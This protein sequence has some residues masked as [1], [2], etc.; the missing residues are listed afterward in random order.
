[1]AFALKHS[2]NSAMR[3]LRLPLV[4]GLACLSMTAVASDALIAPGGRLAVIDTAH[5]H[6][7]V[8]AAVAEALKPRIARAEV[9]YAA[10]SKDAGY[11][12]RRLTL[13]VTDDLDTHNGFS[14]VTPFPIINVQLAPSL[15][16]SFI[17]TGHDEF[18]RTLIHELAHHIS[19]DRDPNAFRRTL[20]HIF[21]RILPNDPLSLAVAYLSTPSHQTMPSFWHEGGA[22][23]A[24][25]EYATGP[26]WAGRGRDSMT[27]MVWRM[28][29]AAGLI[30]PAGDWRLSYHEWPFGSR[31]YIYGVAYTRYLAG[32]VNDRA[33]M[34]QLIERQQHRWAFAFNGGPEKL[35]HKDHLTLI[36]EARAA[37]MT[38]E[39]LAIE[40]LKSKPLTNAKRLTPINGIVGA[41]AWR[42]GNLFAAYNSPYDDP[43][44]V[45]VDASGEMQAAGYHSWLMSP[46]RSLPDGTVVF[47]DA[48]VTTDPWNRSRVSVVWP[49]GSRSV[50]DH[51]RILQ[52]DI[53]RFGNNYSQL[54][55]SI[56]SPS[57]QISGIQLQPD[58]TH[59]LVLFTTWL[60]LGFLH[61]SMT[62]SPSQKI[63]TE[64]RPWSPTF[65]PEH[66]SLTWVETDASGSRLVIQGI[67][68]AH[69]LND[70]FIFDIRQQ[71]VIGAV[72]V[73]NAKAQ[74]PNID[75]L[76]LRFVDLP[77][78]LTQLTKIKS[79]KPAPEP[80]QVLIQ[81]PGRILQ[82]TWS[83][84]G[85][86]LYFCADHTGV[87]N[88]YRLDPDKPNEITAITNTIG[89]V[90]ACVPSPDGKELALVD[91]DR[92]GSFLARIPNDPATWPGTIPTI[93]RAWPAPVGKHA[94]ANAAKAE[95]RF[96]LPADAGD[97]AALT[98][99]P[100]H[101][102]T[103][104]R[105]LFWT[106]T[107][108]A[109][110]EGGY[111]VIGL[112]A[113]PIFSHEF[114]GS[115]GVG[116]NAGSPVG[117]A[118]YA[119]SGWPIDLG[120]VAW[121]AERSYDEQIIASDGNRYDYVEDRRSA[122]VRIGYGLTGMRRRFQFF[123]S[124]GV[125]EYNAVHS[126]EKKYDGLATFNLT[127]FTDVEQYSELTLAYSDATVF[128]TSYTLEDG[129][130]FAVK[131][132]H[133]G[134]D[135][136]MDQDRVIGLGT[137]VFS[138]WPRFGQQLVFGGALGWTEGDDY[139]QNQFS[140]GGTYGLNQL[141]RG[142]GTTQALGQYLVGGSV[143]YRTPV[144]RPF[145]GQSTTPFVDRQTVL[146][147]F[148]DAA[149]VSN[150]KLD[151][152]GEWF[153]SIGANVHM[154][155]MVWELAV[156]PGIGIAYQLDGKEDVR[157]LFGLDFNW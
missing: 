99:K 69:L 102:L 112:M 80:R 75:P 56:S 55:I 86:Y 154:N 137:Y 119:Y 151:G 70:D 19:N 10:M 156:N 103:E 30:P 97:P 83:A 72:D 139:L 32:A 79:H 61:S 53:R 89:G 85:K 143:A 125:A 113:D 92:Q 87:A 12:P 94:G 148:F 50:L 138:F 2:Y 42:D 54:S 130:S 77:N 82:P 9:I 107:T 14:T 131:Y 52:P 157:G 147:L 153:R 73:K 28:D 98:V 8:P 117:L 110:P 35:L 96:R 26:V 37:L 18:E 5:L 95:P 21:G 118:S 108:L 59:D 60:Q 43:E 134:Y 116:P 121:Q 123:A 1:V 57:Y 46:A 49:A 38:E 133:S 7:L 33:S 100:Y 65:R 17:F 132:R 104:V 48:S 20:S 111:G 109:V 36:N 115:A 71:I 25:T 149:K 126:A 27:H 81:L 3:T 64:G 44:F 13:L 84:D 140:V 135:G 24:E 105:P 76:G 66:N 6:A 34:W 11:T 91:H 29:A 74:P 122:E 22:Q 155:W 145:S 67:A 16:P 4:A 63:D 128:P 129:T 23:W 120:I 62:C 78:Q 136:D 101:G 152:T 142:Y 141:P 150:D 144:W 88:A 68:S 106:P 47:S 41:P 31:S 15:Q 45:T 58:G 40:Q 127:P 124:A 51:E 93:T 39:L 114:I 146:E 90:L